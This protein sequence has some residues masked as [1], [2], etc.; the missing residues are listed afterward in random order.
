MTQSPGGIN[1]QSE[2]SDCPVCEESESSKPKTQASNPGKG[3]L[4]HFKGLPGKACRTSR[5]LCPAQESVDSPLPRRRN[6]SR[7]ARAPPW[8]ACVF[9]V[10]GGWSPWVGRATCEGEA[11]T[12]CD[13][14]LWADCASQ[15]SS[16][17]A[18]AGRRGAY[19]LA[20]FNSGVANGSYAYVMTVG[21]PVPSVPTLNRSFGV[22]NLSF[23]WPAGFKLQRTGSVPPTNWV[24]IATNSPHIVPATNQQ[25]YFRLAW[26]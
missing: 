23:S 11:L 12:R 5:E 19:R 20:V 10:A 24:N 2:T 25:G 22:G 14:Q 4:V 21:A 16:E 15:E 9:T 18:P 1:S 8:S 6:R 3:P 26:P 17:S 7:D 13:D